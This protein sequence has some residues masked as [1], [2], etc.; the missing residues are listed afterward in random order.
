MRTGAGYGLVEAVVFVSAPQ[1]M[2]NLTV[3]TAHTYLVGEGGWLV[4]NGPCGAFE[5][6]KSGGRHSGFYQNYLSRTNRQIRRGIK[7]LEAE[8][9]EHRKKIATPRK[10]LPKWDSLDPRQRKHLV[11][12]KWACGV[13]S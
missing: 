2:Y 8:I 13:R 9:A 4:H 11:E 12:T 7:S 3:A 1:P 5:I 6:A 10:F